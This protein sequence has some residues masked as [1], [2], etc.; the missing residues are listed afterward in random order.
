MNE[1]VQ[2]TPKATHKCRACKADVVFATNVDT[3]STQI[4]D[5]EPHRKGN[6]HL[7]ET[8]TSGLMCRVIPA[9][10]REG[11]ELRRDHHASCPHADRFRRRGR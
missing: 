11:L 10:E 1:Q 7:F 9:D 3:Q 8:P 6:I 4:I 5:A 2:V